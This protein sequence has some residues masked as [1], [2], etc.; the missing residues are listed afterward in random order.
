MNNPSN[1][2]FAIFIDEA[3][4]SSIQCESMHETHCLLDICKRWG[5]HSALDDLILDLYFR[6]PE[7]NKSRNM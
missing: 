6:G 2:E 5:S 3:R 1:I 4:F 7:D